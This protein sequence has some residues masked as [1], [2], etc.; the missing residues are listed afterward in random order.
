[1]STQHL[2][3]G[4]GG[5]GGSKG[6]SVEEEYQ[7]LDQIQH[8]LKRPDT[9]IGSV[10]VHESMR[11]VFDLATQTLVRRSVKSVR[12]LE[13]IFDELLVNVGDHKTKHGASVT[14]M[15]VCLSPQEMSV[16]NNGPGLPVVLHKKWGI[17]IPEGVFGNLRTSSNYNDK[18]KKLTGG[19]NGYGAK[20]TNI[21]SKKFVVTTVDSDHKKKFT[22][23]WQDN[24]T[25]KS[26]PSIRTLTSANPKGMTKVQSFPDF[27]RFGIAELTPDIQGI[28]AKRV[29]DLA[30]TCDKLGVTI[31]GEKVPIRGFQSYIKSVAAALGCTGKVAYL[32][33]N[34]RWE[35]GLTMAPTHGFHAVSFVNHIETTKGGTHVN[36]VLAP[37]VKQ[38]RVNLHKETKLD[39][40]PSKIRAHLLLF[41]NSKIE[42]PSFTSQTKEEL[43]TESKRFGSKHGL[44][45]KNIQKLFRDSDIVAR[46]IQESNAGLGGNQVKEIVKTGRVRNLTLPGLEP[47]NFAGKSKSL[48]C[49][50]LLV[51][52]QSAQTLATA[53][54]PKAGGRDYFGSFAL[55]GKLLN[56]RGMDHESLAKNKELTGIIKILNLK[57]WPVDYTLAKNRKTMRY[58]HVIIMT[59]QDDDGAHIAGLIMNF[60][61]Y[62]NKSVLRIPGFLKQFITP[63]IKA[64]KKGKKDQCFFSKDE[65]D[66]WSKTHDPTKYEIKFYKGL[67]TSTAREAREYFA[68]LDTHLQDIE[69]LTEESTKLIK[70]GFEKSQV[71]AR[72]VWITEQGGKH[73]KAPDFTTPIRTYDNFFAS[74]FMEYNMTSI[75]RGIPGLD[76]LKLSQRQVLYGSFVHSSTKKSMKVAVLANKISE[77]VAYHHGEVSLYSTI[78]GMA[79]TFVGK[80]NLS[81]LY[82]D[83]QFGT[84]REGGK[85]SAAPRYIFTRLQEITK[86]V[87]PPADDPI[88]VH[89]LD[90]GNHVEFD[91][92]LPVIPMSLVNGANGIATGWKTDI[93]MYNPLDV[94]RGIRCVL[95]GQPFE[96][97]PWYK[98]FVG[99]IKKLPDGNYVTRGL[100][101]FHPTK[102]R[103]QVTELPVG[104]WTVKFKT[105]IQELQD[106]GTIL[107]KRKKEGNKL[108]Q[109]IRDNSTDRTVNT[110]LDLLPSAMEIYRKDPELF[111]KHFGLETKLYTS[112]MYLLDE[113]D[114]I[115]KYDEAE[116]ILRAYVPLRLKGYTARKTHQLRVMATEIQETSQRR[117]FVQGVIDETIQIMNA[118]DDVICQSM[119]D[120]GILEE[121]HDKFL[122][123]PIKSLSQKSIAKMDAQ[124][125]K[126]RHAIHV[127]EKLSSK[128]LWLQDLDRLGAILGETTK[129]KHHEDDGGGGGKKMK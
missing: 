4:G 86:L 23:T 24:M 52:G 116:D 63:I 73:A 65:F 35:I 14:R 6:P 70:R 13:K 72:K 100:F 76:G 2:D 19:R 57:P 38:L 112:N 10:A 34:D 29:F 66:R 115:Q 101:E 121:F 16:Q 127:L 37:I 125:D 39:V 91:H 45:P 47:A 32:R 93:P 15:A 31:N 49:H 28:L 61:E 102:P 109:N 94:I 68:D 20:L 51:E 123:L 98:G 44:T 48:Q 128:E 12:G 107:P 78:V 42:N 41:V 117:L 85:D 40:P 11:L 79:Q 59:D 129:Q 108:V 25:T 126:T 84:R 46:I 92:Y 58:G 95:D 26:K 74:S 71:H 89:R 7:E 62:Y 90:D 81:L 82:P 53:G 87:F 21:F 43:S 104:S 110:T 113:H 18:K 77:T 96:L 36:Y 83:G 88:L 56:P 17:T 75:F 111:V 118:Q 103:V 30:G 114:A 119:T 124:L 3:G 64:K 80:N 99:S 97:T 105:K 120:A 27:S 22:M 1:M 69:V 5:G 122:G 8:A 33:L 50:M 67:G 54:I 60:L 106:H 9:L 55:K